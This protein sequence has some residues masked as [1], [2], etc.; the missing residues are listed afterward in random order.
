MTTE[1]VL[2]PTPEQ[3]AALAARPADSPVLMVNLL[4]FRKPGGE[5]RYLQYGEAVAPHLERVGAKIR[6][7]AAAPQFVIGDADR[8]WWDAII[9]VEYPSPSA[10]LEMVSADDYR[11]IHVHR[12]AALVRGDLIA[13][14][15]WPPAAD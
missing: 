13:T 10:F 15:A 8:P 3:L 11:Q 4:Q 14:S 9:V 7:A 6:Y 12:A 1:S 5:Q 2:E